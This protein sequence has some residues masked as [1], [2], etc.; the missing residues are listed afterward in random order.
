MAISTFLEMQTE[1]IAHLGNHKQA[2]NALTKEWINRVYI[3]LT[4]VFRFHD[5]EA[6]DTSITT[7]NGTASY[8]TPSGVR[9]ITSIRDTTNKL[10][11]TPKDI[12]WYETQDDSSDTKSK[13]EF[14]LRYGANIILWPTPDGAYATRIRYRKNPT[15]LSA[16]GDVT[17]LPD[18]WDDVIILLTASK[19]AF[20]LS[21][22][23][24]G[25][26]LKSEG[27]SVLSQIKED[28]S[29]EQLRRVGQ[30]QPQRKG[31]DG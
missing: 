27:L 11:L 18:E 25:M 16:D 26:N 23:R 2:T 1:V 15:A 8:A 3:M 22:D 29:Q 17:V 31:Q 28:I 14:W 20:L 7:V 30:I 10:L 6:S 12:D 19:G 4:S 9:V 5:L 24:R 21:M 13:P